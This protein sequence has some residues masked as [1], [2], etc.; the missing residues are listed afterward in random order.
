M[1]QK[2]DSRCKIIVTYPIMPC[3]LCLYAMAVTEGTGSSLVR[4][5][6]IRKAKSSFLIESIYA[7]KV[8][9]RA[10]HGISMVET[11]FFV[12]RLYSS[13]NICA[14]LKQE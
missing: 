4:L 1:H 7:N 6:K 5:M 3:I 13:K 10:R 9:I 2:L 11:K 12:S 14:L 8:I